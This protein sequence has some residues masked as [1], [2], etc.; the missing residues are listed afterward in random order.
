MASLREAIP[1]RG[2][3]DGFVVNILGKG[4]GK[5]D[6]CLNVPPF[7][8]VAQIFQRGPAI[9]WNGVALSIHLRQRTRL[10]ADSY[11]CLFV[12]RSDAVL[13]NKVIEV[14]CRQR[15]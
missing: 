4:R 6:L 15:A 12:R 13:F 8:S 2:V 5:F 1:T 10:V 3:A 14:S 9:G 7:R 11:H